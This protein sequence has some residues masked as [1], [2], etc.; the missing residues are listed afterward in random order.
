M[1]SLL[2]VALIFVILS[3]FGTPAQ[4]RAEHQAKVI[5]YSSPHPKLA[6]Q[7]RPKYPKEAKR[8]G[9]EGRVSLH[10]IVGDDGSVH[11]IEVIRGEEPFLQAAKTAVAQWKYQPV[12]LDGVAVE[13]DTAVDV[14]FE[15]P[16]QKSKNIRLNWRP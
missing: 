1:K 4:K 11:E 14:I 16:K 10:L 5:C 9:I 3:P 7:V 13:S 2:I 8:G 6:L 12:V 15:I